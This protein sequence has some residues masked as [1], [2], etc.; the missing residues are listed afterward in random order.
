MKKQALIL[1]ILVSM[2]FAGCSTKRQ[3]FEPFDENITGKVSFEG[4]LPSSIVASNAAGATLANGAVITQNGLN[5]NIK[6]AK[7]EKFLGEF[8]GKFVYTNENG[9]LKVSDESG[10]LLLDSAID[11]QAL[12][13]AI[14][15]DDLAVGGSNKRRTYCRHCN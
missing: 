5:S 8:E 14:S 9:A 13:A 4:S 2:F 6:L 3:Y 7:G 10:N 11:T 12:S 15:G 1:T